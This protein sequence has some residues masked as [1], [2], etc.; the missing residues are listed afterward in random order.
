MRTILLLCLVLAG[1]DTMA[2]F[3]EDMQQA[4]SGLSRRATEAKYGSQPPPPVELTPAPYTPGP[5]QA[6]YQMDEP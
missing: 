6:P 1:C 3:G 4:G 5:Y 2:G